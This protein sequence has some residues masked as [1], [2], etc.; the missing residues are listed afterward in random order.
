MWGWL[1]IIGFLAVGLGVV[2][3]VFFSSFKDGAWS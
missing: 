1:G 3:L 2:Y